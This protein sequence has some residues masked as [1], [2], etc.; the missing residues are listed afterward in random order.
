MIG[1]PL[2]IA[3]SEKSMPGIKPGPLGWHTS[4]LT[5]ELQEELL[6]TNRSRY[7][8][9]RQEMESD[10]I[11]IRACTHKKDNIFF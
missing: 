9:L 5:K 7:E 1:F 11:I 6:K 10:P 3:V 8:M 4:A 2:V